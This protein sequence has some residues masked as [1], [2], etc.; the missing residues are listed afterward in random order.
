MFDLQDVLLVDSVHICNR[1]VFEGGVELYGHAET[2]EDHVSIA[3]L[4]P[5]CLVRDFKTWGAVDC[6]VNSGHL[7]TTETLVQTDFT[8]SGH[9]FTHRYVVVVLGHVDKSGQTLAEP[10][11]D[12]PVHVDG[13]GFETFLKPAHGVILECAGIFAQIH[14]SY[15]CQAEAADGNKPCSPVRER[16]EKQREERT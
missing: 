6:P 2:A 12:L 14:A 5:K 9:P 4:A 1:T 10:H 7:Q 8:F 16:G 15:L 3:V 11:G 13:E